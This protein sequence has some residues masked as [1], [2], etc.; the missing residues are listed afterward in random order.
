MKISII[1]AT[2]NAEA[3]ILDTLASL[4]A[5]DYPREK[6]EWIVMDGA[7][8]DATVSRIHESAFRPDRM[9]SEP[10]NGIYDALNK[11]VMKATGDIVGFLH[12]DDMLAS[13]TVLNRVACA[14]HNSGAEAVYGDLQYVRQQ[15]DGSFPVVRHW[16]SGVYYRR[17][18]RWGW[19]PPHPS[20][21][22]KRDLYERCRL[23]PG[24]YFDVRY[25]CAADYD[26]MMR[27]LSRYEVEPAYLRM[28]LVKMRLGGMSNRS[29]GH[30]IQKSKED[31]RII[32]QNR[33]GGVLTLAGKNFSK[34]H[35]FIAR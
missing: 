33:L 6:I 31:W 4:A 3:T 12:A 34:L 8:T 15:S 9:V 32:R 13:P 14:F 25:K 17:K 28:V 18:L 20:L 35:Q 29:M 11:G 2:Y 26:F 23:D 10:D 1:T 21:F 30:I 19:M 24:V 7:S 27:L 16:E 5:Q 22:L